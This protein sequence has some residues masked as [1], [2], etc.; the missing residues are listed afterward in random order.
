MKSRWTWIAAV[1]LALGCADINVPNLNNL[2][3][4]GLRTKPTRPL[5][6]NASTGLLIGARSYVAQANGYVAMLGILGRESYNF[7]RADPRFISEMLESPVLDPGSPA[8]GGNFW[9]QPYSNIRNANTLIVALD[10]I[11]TD[12]ITG[13]TNEERSAII[14]FAETIQALDFLAIAMTRYNDTQCG[15][16]DVNRAPDDA[17]AP[18]VGKDEVLA[19]ISDLL[20][21][22]RGKLNAAAGGAD[23][24]PFQLGSGFAGF[25][26]PS[27]FT[28]VNR[29]LAARV[30]VYRQRWTEAQTALGGSFIDVAKPMSLGAY[31]AFGNGSGDTPNNLTSPNE[32]AHP[33]LQADAEPGDARIF[34]PTSKLVTLSTTTTLRDISSNQLFTLYPSGD[35]PV[36][37]IRNEELILLR[38]EIATQQDDLAAALVDV[39]FIR[40]LYGLAP[41]LSADL[42]TKDKMIDEILKQRRYSLLFEGGHRWIDLRRYNKLDASLLDLPTHY[43]HQ[44]YPIPSAELDARQATP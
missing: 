15:P 1:A 21:D 43:V 41:K 25:D 20:D 35:T 4:D 13:V 6:L 5:I 39:N 17:L 10:A 33:K 2:P 9:L 30:L 16:V 42:D 7:D 22:A 31:H 18:I 23:V 11:D 29:A 14:G 34:G 26:K 24:F 27:A 36:P 32:F 40:G 8:F 19:H 38:A 28:K 3:Y 44:Q 37:I 12:P